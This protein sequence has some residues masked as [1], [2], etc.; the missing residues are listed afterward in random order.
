MQV[1][2]NKIY[3][4]ILFTA[5]WIRAMFGFISDELMPFISSLT[6]IVYLLFD[7]TLVILGCLTIKKRWDLMILFSFLII[8]Y[9]TTCVYNGLD[10]LF[11][12]NGLR[13]FITFLFIIPIL[14]YFFAE[15]ERKE[16]FVESFDKQL[17]IFLLVQAIC[18][19]WQFLKYGA[20]DHGGGSLGNW[21]SG[22]ISIMIFLISFYLI[23]KR[24]DKKNYIASL[25]RNK[26]YVIL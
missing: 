7:A 20:N 6:P 9:I 3:Q 8:F 18:L 2:K 1:E 21:N 25:W 15:E 26:I 11:F 5:F 19:T 10:L 12:I 14:S 23:Q 24:I 17:Y 22:V 13:D 4:N 16:A